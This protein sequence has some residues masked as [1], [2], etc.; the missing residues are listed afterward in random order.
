V[1]HTIAAEPEL[2]ITGDRTLHFDARD[3]QPLRVVTPKPTDLDIYD[4]IWHRKVGERSASEIISQG[5]EGERI[6]LLGS[7]SARTGSFTLA[8]E[9]Q[10]AQPILSASVVGSTADAVTTSQIASPNATWFV[11]QKRL[12]LVDAGAG[13]AEAFDAVD[14][15]GA[16]ALVSR[17]AQSGSLRDQATAAATAGADMLL[18]YNTTVSEWR[19]SA[20]NATIPVYRLEIEDGQALLDALAARSNV[21]VDLSG[22]RDATYQY[23]LAYTAADRIPDG[24]TYRVQPSSLATVT[25]DYRQNSSRQVRAESWIPYFDGVGVANSMSQPR[26]QPLVRTD[27]VNT[28]GVEWQRFGQ[29]H[30]FLGFYFTTTAP[31]DYRAGGD[32]HQLWWGPLV[33]PAVPQIPAGAASAPLLG[34]SYRPVTR[35]RDAIR[36]NLPHYSFGSGLTSTI[37]QQF[38]DRSELTLSRDGEVVGTSTWPNVQW[39]VPADEATY[40][41]TLDVVNGSG[42]WSDTSVNTETTWRFDSARTDETGEVLPLV[43]VDYELDTDAFNAVPSGQSYPLVLRPDYQPQADGPGDF[44]AEVDVSFDDGATWQSAPVS[45]VDEGLQA[46]VPA[47]T[48]PGFASVRV[49]VTDADGNQISQ[50]IDRAW[51]IAAP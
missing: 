23:E 36:I 35:Y 41:L 21:E 46:Q 28:D 13:T 42:N 27:Y 31:T 48:G 7:E 3:A 10:Q 1:Q 11:G 9:W 40:D 49:V 17:G 24:Q 14:A 20:S 19:E 4:V 6:F 22:V 5:V 50:R 44:D 2:H 26:S 51:K 29:P 43:Q 38:G 45:S 12:T 37:Y 32:Y 16:A 34:N 18:V 39:T 15:D 8:S 30:Q 33:H 47:A 25:S